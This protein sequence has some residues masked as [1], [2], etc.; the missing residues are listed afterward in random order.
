MPGFSLRLSVKEKYQNIIKIPPDGIEYS[1]HYLIS[2]YKNF[3][4]RSCM[5]YGKI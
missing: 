1:M 5:R 4:K 3:C 2:D